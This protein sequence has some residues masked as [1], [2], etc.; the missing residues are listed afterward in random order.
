MIRS[1]FG[2]FILLVLLSV[3][4]G[5]NTRIEG[6]LDLNAA[7][8][9]FEAERSCDDCCKY[10][11]A[12]LSLTQKWNAD[13]FSNEDTLYDGQGQKYL[14][15]DL[16][17]FLSSWAWQDS[18][19][20]IYTVDSVTATC[21]TE[22]LTYTP[23][24]ITADSRKFSYALGPIRRSPITDSLSMVFGLVEDFSCLDPTNKATPANLTENSP[25][26]NKQTGL[27]ET[28]RLVLQRNFETVTFDTIFLTTKV[29]FRYAYAREFRA[30][31]N[32]TF[33]LAVDYAQWFQDVSVANLASFP[34]SIENHLSGSITPT[35]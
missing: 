34:I 35:N 28:L 16:K 20:K 14:I 5:C 3:N 21:G 9:D 26:W 30:G 4:M 33:A 10:P 18:D 7:N 11:S 24:M 15:I 1:G 31:K 22:D 19:G 2:L 27:L 13:N 6:C 17:Y 25:L 32:D 8:F 23:D 12:I 29:D